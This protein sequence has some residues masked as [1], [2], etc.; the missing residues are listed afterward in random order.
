MFS[1]ASQGGAN[2]LREVLN[3]YHKGSGQLV[4]YDKS[5][6]F[7]SKNCSQDMKQEVS[8]GLNIQKEALAERYLGLPTEVGRSGLFEYLLAQV[9]GKIESWCGREASYTGREV[10][11]KLIAQ[12]VPA[13]SM[14]CFLLPIITCKKIT[15]AVANYWWSSSTDN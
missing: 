4:N 15:A 14:S 9:I 13:Y 3:R 6:I 10:L 2:I 1:E 11:I 7:F 5:A 8:Q 12:T